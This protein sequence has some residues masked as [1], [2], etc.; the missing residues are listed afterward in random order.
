MLTLELGVN[1]N[2]CSQSLDFNTVYVQSPCNPLNEDNTH[3][4]YMGKGLW[5]QSYVTANSQLISLYWCQAP[6]RGPWPEY[7]YCQ[8]IMGLLMQSTLSNKWLG[9]KFTTAAVP[10]QCSHSR[11]WVQHDSCPY[12]TVSC[13]RLPQPGRPGPHIYIPQGQDGPVHPQALGPGSVIAG[14]H[15]WALAKATQNPPTIPPLLHEYPLPWKHPTGY[16]TKD[17][18][19]ASSLKLFILSSSFLLLVMGNRTFMKGSQCCYGTSI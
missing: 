18:A 2:E 11:V 14:P 15:N 5:S 16:Q 6:I 7:Y 9:L 1:S 19:I 12:F 8:S 4:F 13:L 3:I 10:H 17:N